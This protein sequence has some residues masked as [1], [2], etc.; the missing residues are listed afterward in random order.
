MSLAKKNFKTVLNNEEKNY[1]LVSHYLPQYRFTHIENEYKIDKKLIHSDKHRSKN[2]YNYE[3]YYTPQLKKIVYE[4]Y[5][6][7]FIKFNYPK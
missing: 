4:L 7:D 5:E 3:D 1:F 2:K 6:Q